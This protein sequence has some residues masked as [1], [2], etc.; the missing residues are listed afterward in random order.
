MCDLFSLSFYD[1]YLAF[2]RM[3]GS[4]FYL[5]MLATARI[6][7]LGL[8]RERSLQS[9]SSERDEQLDLQVLL[10]S[11]RN[12]ECRD[13]R[14]KVYA[15]RGIAGKAFAGKA[16]AEGIVANYSQSVERVYIDCARHWLRTRSDLRGLTAV[17]LCYRLRSSIQLPLWVPDWS[18]PSCHGGIM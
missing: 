12:K 7:E 14:D 10:I 13:L 15:L 17:K 2:T 18:Q 8:W 9:G 4:G 11:P 5:F 16:F 3:A 1:L 6:S